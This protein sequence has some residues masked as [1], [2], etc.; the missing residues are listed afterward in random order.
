MTD[1]ISKEHRSWNMSR[2]SGR[3][4]KP[5]ITLRSLLHREGFRFRIHSSELLGRPDIVLKKYRTAIFVNGC[6]WH[7]H[8]E[9]RYATIPTTKRAFWQEKFRRTRERD[10]ENAASLQSIGWTVIVVW[11]CELSNSASDVLARIC[12]QLRA[13]TTVAEDSRSSRQRLSSG[14]GRK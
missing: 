4:T 9:C 7:Q 8:V 5:E 3:N 2:I 14:E 10:Q 11:E 13:I 6:F 1:R 12:D